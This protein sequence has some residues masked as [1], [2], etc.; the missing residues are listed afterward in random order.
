[1]KIEQELKMVYAIECL[2]ENVLTVYPTLE[3]LK[4]AIADVLE[5]AGQV[6]D[7]GIRIFIIDSFEDINYDTNKSCRSIN[8]DIT[9]AI[10]YWVS[11]NH[12]KIEGQNEIFKVFH[13]KDLYL[14]ELNVCA[15]ENKIVD[16]ALR[17][18]DN[19]VFGC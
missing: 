10:G 6:D 8:Q 3:D 19:P 2:Y 12:F 5:N 15:N 1:M 7:L 4:L 14:N 17:S 9:H 13:S 16:D 11:Q 18:I